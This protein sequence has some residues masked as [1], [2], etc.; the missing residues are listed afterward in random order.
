M[1]SFYCAKDSNVR[2]QL[3]HE[4]DHSPVYEVMY[5]WSYPSNPA[6]DLMACTRISSADNTRVTFL[7]A[8][9][10]II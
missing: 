6:C 4:A 10:S 1:Y 7:P 2:K 9:L 8:T 3:G 5:E